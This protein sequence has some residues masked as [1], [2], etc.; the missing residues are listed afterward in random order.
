MIILIR[1]LGDRSCKKA[2]YNVW[3]MDR[4]GILSDHLKGPTWGGA[5]SCK[6]II[7][8]YINVVAK[9]LTTLKI[10]CII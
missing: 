2:K 8:D 5:M 7:N 4:T 9:V 3:V 10:I 1:N 6:N